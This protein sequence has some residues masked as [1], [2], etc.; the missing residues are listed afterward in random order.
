M[1]TVTLFFTL[2]SGTKYMTTTVISIRSRIMKLYSYETTSHIHRTD[3]THIFLMFEIHIF[4][5]FNHVDFSYTCKVSSAKVFIKKEPYYFFVPIP[6]K[7]GSY[8]IKIFR[9]NN[10]SLYLIKSLFGTHSQFLH[11]YRQL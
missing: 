3:T 5:C 4:K 9:Q 2:F 11:L 6:I 7:V 1:S 10:K 8:K